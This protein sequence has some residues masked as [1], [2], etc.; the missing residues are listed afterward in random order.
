MWVFVVKL[1]QYLKKNDTIIWSCVMVQSVDHR[2]LVYVQLPRGRTT[3]WL[4]PQFWSCKWNR[5]SAQ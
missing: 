1:M 3:T 4:F 5:H 2:V